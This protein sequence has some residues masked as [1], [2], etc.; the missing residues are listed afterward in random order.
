[1]LQPPKS[2]AMADAI[3]ADGAIWRGVVDTYNSAQAS[4]AA[5]KTETRVRCCIHANHAKCCMH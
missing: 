5:T 1:M 2:A 4:G 3:L